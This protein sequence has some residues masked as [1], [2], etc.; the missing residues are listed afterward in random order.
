[1]CCLDAVGYFKSDHS[2]QTGNRFDKGMMGHVAGHAM[3]MMQTAISMCMGG[4]LE[5]HPDLRVALL[6]STYP[7]ATE[8]FLELPM[9]EAQRRKV[10]GENC[11][12]LYKLD[13]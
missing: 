4:V 3:E 1:M 12:N 11:V 5:R 2:A 7:H 8:A 6:N 10:L 13:A 9:S